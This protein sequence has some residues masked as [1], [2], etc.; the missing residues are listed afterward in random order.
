MCFGVFQ[1]NS[2][3]I[4]TTQNTYDLWL[5]KFANLRQNEPTLNVCSCLDGNE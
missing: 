2:G 1:R 3:V 5:T 4:L